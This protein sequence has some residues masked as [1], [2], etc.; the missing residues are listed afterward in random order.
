VAAGN[1]LDF[2]TITTTGSVTMG[3]PGTL[4]GSTS[5]G[6]TATSHTHAITTDSSG[7]CGSGVICAGDHTHPA[8]QVTTGTFGTG[9][10]VMADNLTV[11]AVYLEGNT[12][13]PAL[14]E[15]STCRIIKSPNGATTFSVCN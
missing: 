3:T 12:T 9:N 6:V 13:N 5:N 8:S 7:T 10:Y 14:T 1:G 4:T 11:E 15:N 2:T